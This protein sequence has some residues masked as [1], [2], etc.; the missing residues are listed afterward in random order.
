MKNKKLEKLVLD[1][2]KNRICKAV[3]HESFYSDDFWGLRKIQ[4][5]YT[6]CLMHNYFSVAKHLNIL[7]CI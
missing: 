1:K 2:E 3:W 7:L 5:Q 6:K 4:A